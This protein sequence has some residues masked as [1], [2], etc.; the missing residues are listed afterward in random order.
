MA[1]VIKQGYDI[2]EWST[3]LPP[4]KTNRTSK[5]IFIGII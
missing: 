5:R 3:P 1:N 4:H 2:N